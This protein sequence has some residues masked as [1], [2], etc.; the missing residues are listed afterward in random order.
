[1]EQTWRWF[2]PGDRVTLRDAKEAGAEGIVTALHEVPAGEAWP[3][4]LI[5]KRKA[6]IEAAGLRWSVVESLDVTERIK[7]RAPGWQRDTE[8]FKTS[9]L[10]LAACGIRTVAYN[11]MP[12]F[13][14]TRTHLHAPVP[15]GG[16]TL[17]FDA[18]AFA[19]FDLYL[20][21][22][23]G[24]E[25]EWGE[26]ASQQAQAYF[27]AMTPHERDELLETIL[28]G[29]PGGN[30]RYTLQGVRDLVEQYNGLDASSFREH[31]G[32]FLRSVC[33]VAE[34]LG[35]R[36]GVHPDDPPRPLLGLPR[37]VSTAEDL[38]WL[39]AQSAL[40]ANGITF[41]TGALGVRA[42]ND[43]AAMVHRF[44]PRIAFFH[45]RSTQREN[46]L[47]KAGSQPL[48]S[49]FEAAHLE[50]DADLIGILLEVVK[51]EQCGECAK[52]PFRS[53]HGQELLNDCERAAAPGYPAVGRLRGLAEL[54]GAIRMAERITAKVEHDE[55]I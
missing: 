48:E 45:L 16:F 41:C 43:L 22:R 3:V 13:S 49:F 54:R 11:W 37:I 25:Q 14:W 23:N 20:L 36:L 31:A 28:C 18:L 39:M 19:A 7:M 10:N 30:G 32:E 21:K 27:Q 55:A 6:E 9:L 47:V 1:M 26:A 15:G 35:M 38:D 24:A 29:L 52:L 33:P 34:E 53:D 4:E 40:T 44:L 50:G 5:R 8:N 51:Q 2:G 12:L 17:R 46:T 42:D